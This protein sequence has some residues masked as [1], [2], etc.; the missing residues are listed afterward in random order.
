MQKIDAIQL[1]K[2]QLDILQYVSEFC[3]ANDIHYWLDGGTL[4]GAIRHKGY[5]PWDDDIDL[6]MLRSDYDRFSE[7]F[8]QKQANS[9]YEF[10]SAST[11]KQFHIPFGKVLD[12]R[13]ILYEPDEQGEKSAVGVDIFVYDNAPD[14]DELLQKMYEKRD[15]YRKMDTTQSLNHTPTGNILRRGALYVLHGILQLW[16]KHFFAR[17][18]AENAKKYN[19]MPTQRIGNF[20]GYVRYVCDKRVVDS[21]VDTEFEGKQYKIPV[22]YDEWLRSVYGDYMQLPPVEK[23]VSHHSFVAYME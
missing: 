22:G 10:K 20:T 11:D 7:L 21:F 5:I 6:G 3:E 8:N 1:K 4:I 2:L 17:K 12:K 16:P 14:D 9:P 13:T 19:G 23:R 18:I 15:A